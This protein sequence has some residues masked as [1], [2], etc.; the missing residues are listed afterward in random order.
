MFGRVVDRL[1]GYV[2]LSVKKMRIDDILF[3]HR[4]SITQYCITDYNAYFNLKRSEGK[5]S[6]PNPDIWM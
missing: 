5:L 2:T 3:S 1:A 6:L 4:I